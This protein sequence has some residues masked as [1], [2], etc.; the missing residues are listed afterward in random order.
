MPLVIAELEGTPPV[1]ISDG[2]NTATVT[3]NGLATDG[4]GVTQPV[5][6]ESL[7]LPAGA[8]TETTLGNIKTKTDNLDA[9]IST[10]AT[11]TTLGL[12]KAK[13]DNLDAALSTRATETTLGLVKAKTDNLDAALSTRATET[14]LG[15]V[16]AKTDNLDT[17]LSG[18]KAKTDN[19]DAALSTRATE[20][21]LGLIKAKTDNIPASPSQEHTTAASPNSVRLSDGANFVS[22]ST[23]GNQTSGAQKTQVVSP[24]GNALEVDSSGQAS[25]KNPFLDAAL[26]SLAKSTQQTDGTQ[27]T[28][29]RGGTK[30]ATTPADVTSSV[31]DANHQ[32]LDVYTWGGGEGGS[33]QVEGLAA[34]GATPVG[35]PVQI[36]GVDDTNHVQALLTDAQGRLVTA[37]AGTTAIRRGFAF[38]RTVLSAVTVVEL[39]ET[40]YTEQA[41][42]AQRSIVSSSAADAAAGTGARTV[43]ITYFDNTLAGPYTETVTL[44]GTTPVN[45][46]AT[47]IRFVE[48][49]DVMTVGSGG[50]N[51]GII[52]LKAATG[53]GG[54]TIW[55][56]AA[57]SNQTFSASNHY[58]PAGYTCFITGMLGGIKGA[59]TAGFLIKAA[60]PLTPNATELQIS[61]LLRA[62]SSGQSTRAYATPIVVVGPARVEMYVSPDSTSSRTYYGSFDYYEQVT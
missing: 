25:I 61:D 14:T 36:G 27:R 26:S 24:A 15:L 40:V 8:A 50:S 30:G 47:N 46:T 45:T 58:V 55:S 12:V 28:I 38:G 5:S 56:I 2:T 17:P 51:A 57:G 54:A 10:R 4:S 62:P 13:T 33:Q 37:A 9:A 22:P 3:P 59:D 31:V 60:Y 23:S 1:K 32:A 53:G 43:K 34:D 19:L 49:M 16:K 11:E 42:A 52:S 39:N 20:T 21:T 41:S 35:N 29:M 18:I 7:P 48:K 44:N 6:A